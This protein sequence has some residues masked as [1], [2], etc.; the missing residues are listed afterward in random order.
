MPEPL[1][2]TK[3][4]T[5]Q[6]CKKD[7][8]RE[9]SLTVH[10]CEQKRR[11]D[12]KDDKG[13]QLGLYAYIKFY[14]YAQDRTKT[15]TFEEFRQSPYY[16]AFVKF[17]NYCIRT[18]CIKIER[19]IDFVVR[20]K[21]KL[22][23]WASDKT[24]TEFLDNALKTEN[25]SDALTRAIE[26]SIE[27]SAEKNMQAE[28]LLRYGSTNRICH[29]IVSG[30]LSPWVIY[31]SVSGQEFLGKLTSEQMEMVWDVINPDFWQPQFDA[32]HVDAEYAKEMLKNA[33]W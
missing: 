16:I 13:V 28:D 11:H 21:I 23:S 30:H 31:Q 25:V 15:K 4:Y 17:G 6:Y 32:S 5:C 9:N 10:I 22:D 27:W 24:Y 2:K 14:Q 18:R 12:V 19:F 3:T 33:G 29:A 7:F 26:Y 1:E 20:S 8:K